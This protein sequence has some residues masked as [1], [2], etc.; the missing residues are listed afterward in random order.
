MDYFFHDGSSWSPEVWAAWAQAILSAIAIVVASRMA[1][2]QEKRTTIRKIEAYCEIIADAG[3]HAEDAWKIFK[4]RLDGVPDLEGMEW[5]ISICR[6]FDV[7]PF[8]DTPDYGLY[9]HLRNAES[10]AKSIRKTYEHAASTEKVDARHIDNLLEQF[11][12]LEVSL[13]GAVAIADLID[14]PSL[15]VRAK[16]LLNRLDPRWHRSWPKD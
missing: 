12:K 15:W 8:H 2:R 16:R 1:L 10:A 13:T 9:M 3:H 4:E 5:W 6:V 11:V 7:I 14:P